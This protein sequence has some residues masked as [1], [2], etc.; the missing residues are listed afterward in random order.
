[1]KCA[2]SKST[3]LH[4]FIVFKELCAYK[5]M[6]CIVKHMLSVR[7]SLPYHFIIS[8]EIYTAMC[9][10]CV[11]VGS[12]LQINSTLQV[13]FSCDR[14]QVVVFYLPLKVKH[15]C[16]LVNTRVVCVRGQTVK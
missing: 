7:I 14:Q 5:N 15:A 13:H 4:T 11:L 8:F 16:S 10:K 6:V 9:T 12:G 3:R 2:S 1:M